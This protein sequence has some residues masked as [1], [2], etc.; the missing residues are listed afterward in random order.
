ML[1]SSVLFHRGRKSSFHTL[2]RLR[3]IFCPSVRTVQTAAKSTFYDESV[4]HFANR[5]TRPITLRSLMERGKPPLTDKELLASANL[6]FS[7]LPVR[8]ARRVKAFQKLP[9]IVG[10]NPYIKDVHDTYYESFLKLRDLP[11]I[12]DV[13]EDEECSN[14]LMALVERHT[15]NIP[16]LARGFKECAEYITPQE[17]STFFNDLIQARIGIRLIAEH[18]LALHA[19]KKDYIGVV[20]TR[21]KPDSLIRSCAK[22]VHELCDLNYGTAPRFI[23][24]GATSARFQ[25]VPVHLEYILHELLKNAYRATVEHART[26]GKSDSEEDLPPIAITISQGDGEVGIR[27]RDQ[28]GGIPAIVRDEIFSYS[29][30]TVKD[31][32]GEGRLDDVDIP[33]DQGSVSSEN[34]FSSQTR[35]SMQ[36][37][38]GGPMAGLG[39]GLPMARI[40][41]QSFGGH[42]D[43]IS[44]PAHG[45]DVFLSLPDM[46]NQ[47]VSI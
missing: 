35:L 31:E 45:C 5:E 13:K 29:F 39:F 10:T 8:L 32:F 12:R 26:Q 43:L 23:V 16:K 44:L 47:D 17:V 28:G 27:I 6:T 1:R 25:Y 24:D 15:P 33:L 46:G 4:A 19:A 7:E 14:L 42:L 41:A 2:W 22:A 38:V 3:P 40:Y 18:H 20:H 30:T 37:G 34:V 9:F 21:L 11:V 36:M